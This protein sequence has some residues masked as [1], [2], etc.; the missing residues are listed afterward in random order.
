MIQAVYE[1]QG[2]V[3]ANY[4][5]EAFLLMIEK[6]PVLT[7][8]IFYNNMPR[9]LQVTS[10]GRPLEFTEA[11]YTAY[12]LDKAMQMAEELR[13]KD[14]E[15]GFDFEQDM[16]I[17][18][19]FIRLAEGK[20]QMLLSFHHIILDGHSINR[21]IQ[22]FCLF[23]SG[24]EGQKEKVTYLDYAVWVNENEGKKARN[25]S[26][27]YWKEKFRVVPEP[28]MPYCIKKRPSVFTYRG[29]K[30]S[31]RIS[32]KI[33]EGIVRL[34]KENNTTEFAILTTA[35]V[36]LLEKYTLQNDITIGTVTNG[37][38]CDEIKDTLGMFVKT[39]PLRI[40][41]DQENTL[42]QVI[43]H[44]NEVLC[45]AYEHQAI[46][47][48]ELLEELGVERDMSRNPLFDYMIVMQEDREEE[49]VINGTEWALY[50][51]DDLSSKYDLTLEIRSTEE[52]YL[53]VFEYCT[54]IFDAGTIELL[55]QHFVNLLGEMIE[56]ERKPVNR[57]RMVSDEEQQKI[58]SYSQMM[59]LDN[60]P[61]NAV[62]QFRKEAQ[63]CQEQVAVIEDDRK[64]TYQELEQKSDRLAGYLLAHHIEE[65]ERVGIYGSHS[66]EMIVGILAVLKCKAAYVP[67]D[68]QLPE[69]RI[70]YIL[71]D[72][73]ARFLLSD[74]TGSYTWEEGT[75]LD[76]SQ[77]MTLDIE[78]VPMD[79]QDI[80]QV[81]T[82]R[83]VEE[84]MASERSTA[85]IS[86][87]V[88]S[89]RKFFSW[90][91]AKGYVFNDPS[92]GLKAP[93]VIKN[94]PVTADTTDIE[95]LIAAV[96]HRTAKGKRDIAII[97]LI[98]S[99]GISSAELGKFFIDLRLTDRNIIRPFF[100]FEPLAYFI[101]CLTGFDDIEPVARRSL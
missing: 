1:L 54:D 68:S 17:R 82:E 5:K 28:V 55:K 56:G 24:V 70:Q 49:T 43:T 25:E 60:K 30:E 85:T 2:Q 72:S 42:D 90:A 40:Q 23:L 92:V 66:I 91:F 77:T 15:R 9:P 13:Q 75:V 45:E 52:E 36:L 95:R 84:L 65:G 61:A 83:Y 67:I 69:E 58:L 31:M 11:D 76:I 59:H 29:M 47:F 101:A 87:C 26:L 73:K 48:E 34:A 39:L 20:S 10:T 44:V 86:R 80:S 96:N 98:S 41:I 81:M 38:V 62:E 7:T 94:M 51:Y 88:T 4:L 35:F 100:F 99:T 89:F 21:L 27:A 3:D 12:S 18:M 74:G 32:S 93:K 22:K 19:H 33:K 57:I 8:A 50:P 71:E 16:L 78:T 53:C 97:K 37:R 64:L 14:L 79:T 46:S 6:H 63:T